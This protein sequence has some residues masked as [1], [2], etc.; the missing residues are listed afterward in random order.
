MICQQG[1]KQIRDDCQEVHCLATA[2]TVQWCSSKL[3]LS[4]SS[5]SEKNSH[6]PEEISW[7]A[8]RNIGKFI[9]LIF[10]IKWVNWINGY[11][12]FYIHIFILVNFFWYWCLQRPPLLFWLFAKISIRNEWKKTT[13]AASCL[14]SKFSVFM[15]F[16][17]VAF[18]NSI[19]F[20]CFCVRVL[21]VE[22]CWLLL[23]TQDFCTY[24]LMY[25]N[26]L[27][28]NFQPFSRNNYIIRFLLH[29]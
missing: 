27:V 2:I 14:V 13:F 8:L 9:R 18:R 17:G 28:D 22:L 1:S 15:S 29:M 11:G 25:Y 6:R 3:R 19:C 21:G 12:Q 16:F 26:Y 10:F 4:L 7:W 20:S 24:T 5:K 23:A